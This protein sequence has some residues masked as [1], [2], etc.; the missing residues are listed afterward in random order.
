MATV[1][2]KEKQSEKMSGAGSPVTE[3]PKNNRKPMLFGILGILLV[4]AVV[5]GIR[6]MTWS[7]SHASTDDASITADV[8][9]IAP[10]VSGTVLKVAVSENDHVK[11]GDVLV[12]L[13]PSTY[14]TA[15]AQAQANLDL[16]LAQAKGASASVQLTEQTSKAQVTQAEGIVHQSN[17]GI[18]G[19]YA[20]LAKAKA[21]VSQA[22]AQA[23]SAVASYYGAQSNVAIAIANRQKAYDAI[24]SASAQVLTAEAALNSAKANLDAYK[25]SAENAVKQAAR[26][27]TLYRQ[28]AISGQV[29]DASKSAADVA[30]AEVVASS[31]QVAQAE[32][33]IQQKKADLR[34][35][36]NQLPAAEAA[37][38][39]AK[40]MLS[41]SEAQSRAAKDTIVQFQAQTRA[42]EALLSQSKA[43]Q[44]QASG[45]MIQANTGPLQVQV[46]E[47]ARLQAEAKVEQARAA[48]KDAQINLARTTIVAPRDGRISKNSVEEGN[49]VQPGTTLMAIVP[50]ED[51]WVVANFKETQLADVKPGQPV[52]VEVD[53]LPGKT[54][55]GKV[56]SISAG[57]GSTFA[58]LPADN[59][60]GNFTKVVQ[61]IPVKILLEPGQPNMDRLRVGMSVTATIETK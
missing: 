16:A 56:G 26:N 12:Q 60:T 23:S 42:A 61:R 54:F 27:E 18:Y 13:D 40:S 50:D 15:L 4:V 33:V 51:A 25:A 14:Q 1:L 30:K 46:S 10:Q 55:K 6:F 17:G 5:M 19:S 7:S 34:S 9:N 38:S 48:L 44:T 36:K 8:V 37:V 28:G 22:K 57:T 41:A 39:Q 32:A 59:S 20:D 24:S 43:R 53:A 21:A 29:Y 49:L 3:T 52:E 11:K 58:L 47:S 45:Q 35:A 2:E 31:Q